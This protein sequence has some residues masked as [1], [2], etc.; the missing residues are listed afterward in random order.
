VR[1]TRRL[2]LRIYIHPAVRK[3]ALGVAA[4]VMLGGF[5]Y[6]ATNAVQQ[7]ESNRGKVASG[8]LQIVQN[9]QAPLRQESLVGRVITPT[10]SPVAYFSGAYD[11]NDSTKLPTDELRNDAWGDVRQN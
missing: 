3:A 11:A 10:T 6:L 5:G 1:Q 4:A 2:R 7:A 9:T 8:Y